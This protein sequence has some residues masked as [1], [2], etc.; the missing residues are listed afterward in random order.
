[1]MEPALA[2]LERRG[3]HAPAAC[4]RVAGLVAQDIPNVELFRRANA[5][6]PEVFYPE[7]A[8]EFRT[9]GLKLPLAKIYRRVPF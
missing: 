4:A 1:M 8:I 9:I 3:T 7:D 5:W 6:R 2:E